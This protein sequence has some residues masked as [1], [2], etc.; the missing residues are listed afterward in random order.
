MR[1]LLRPPADKQASETRRIELD[2]RDVHYTLRRSARRTL[3]MTIDR[4][5][6][7]VSIPLRVT[8]RETEGFLRE[9]SDW[10]ITKLDEWAQ[11]PV[12]PRL[13]VVDGMQLSLLG[14]SCTVRLLAGANRL[15]W[16][17]GLDAREVRVQ[18]R[19]GADAKTLLLRGWQAY[20]LNYFKGRVEE[21]AFL[22]Q[23]FAPECAL[24]V[25]RLTNARTRWGSCSRH[26]GIRLNWRLIHL[27][28]EQ[29]DYVVAHEMAHLVE[30]NHSDRFW[31]VVERLCPQYHT[32]KAALAQ[33]NRLI[34][35]W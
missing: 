4:R 28:P 17:E 27:P 18:L 9:R 31:A 13:V 20:A 1:T 6:L 29:I 8:M 21:Y 25:V 5:G 35:A 3:G 32:A 34:P 14:R 22:L 12:P 16:I 24:P 30:M 10:I 19:S 15:Q 33:A 2:G 7:T 26:S 23:Q 11:R